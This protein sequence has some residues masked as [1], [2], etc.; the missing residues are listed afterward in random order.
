MSSA[1]RPANNWSADPDVC[2]LR[3]SWIRL[4]ISS[5]SFASS[6]VPAKFEETL[7]KVVPVSGSVLTG[8]QYTDS[9]MSATDSLWVY[10]PFASDDRL[11]VSVVSDDGLYNASA[12]YALQGKPIGQLTLSFPTNQKAELARY[13]PGRLSLLG[14]VRKTCK[15]AD[16]PG[17]TKTYLPLGWSQPSSSKISILVNAPDMDVQVFDSGTR[18]YTDCRGSISRTPVAFG[19]ECIFAIGNGTHEWQ[20]YILRSSF[21]DT[22]PQ[23]PLHIGYR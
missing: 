8:V 20:G 22:L 5:L 16:P 12:E 17:F 7:L 9:T 23:I 21:Q 6:V 3:H 15:G 13:G 1:P 18:E 2:I 11:C 4:D 14:A 10:L 19:T